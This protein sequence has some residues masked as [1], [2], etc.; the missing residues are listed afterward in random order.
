MKE[1][2]SGRKTSKVLSDLNRR[3]N[4][5]NINQKITQPLRQKGA[6]NERESEILALLR[7]RRNDAWALRKKNPKASFPERAAE[8]LFHFSDKK[9][10]PPKVEKEERKMNKKIPPMSQ[11][12]I[13]AFFSRTENVE[14][15]EKKFDQNLIEILEYLLKRKREQKK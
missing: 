8:I 15:L 1:N 12:K 11:E 5:A 9:K 6:R 2:Q 14:K 10:P 3:I 13:D 4:L 7:K